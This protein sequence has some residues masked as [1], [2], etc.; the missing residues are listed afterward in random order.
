MGGG[1]HLTI[2]VGM[3]DGAFATQKL[4]A[5]GRAFDH[6]FQMPGFCPEIFPGGMLAAGIDSHI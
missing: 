6:L 2:I 1:G 3:G 4:P 5:R